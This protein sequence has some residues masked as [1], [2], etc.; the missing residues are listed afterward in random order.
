MALFLLMFDRLFDANFFNVAKGA[1]PLLWEHLFWIFGH[2]EV[3]IMILPGF[4][5]V[6]EMHP[7]LLPQADLRLP[8]H[9]R[10]RASP[11]ASWAGACG[12]TT[13]SPPASGPISVTAFSLATMFIAVPTGVKILNWMATMWGGKLQFTIADAVLDRPGRACSPSVACRA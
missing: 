9:G 3:Y 2:P 11:S 13:C 6:S 1:D 7:G 8:V 12:P 10:S 4:G 5:I